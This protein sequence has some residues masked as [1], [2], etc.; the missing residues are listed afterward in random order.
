MKKRLLS[1]LLALSICFGTAVSVSAQDTDDLSCEAAV[2][3][4]NGDVDGDSELTILD[5]V[6]V[7]L[8]INGAQ[9]LSDECEGAADVNGD[10]ITDIV[11]VT[12]MMSHITGVKQIPNTEG[13]V[14]T[15][16][17]DRFYEDYLG[18]SGEDEEEEKP[19]EKV[20][21]KLVVIDAGHQSKANLSPEPIAPGAWQ[22]KAKVTGGTYGRYTGVYEYQLNLIL[23]QKLEKE[24]ESRGYEVIMC[25]TNNDVNISNAERAEIANNA[26]ADAFIR[27]HAN[28]SDY[29]Y[30][31]GAMTICQTKNNPYNAALY[32]KSKSLS[33]YVLD[34]LVASAG[35]KKQYVWETDTMSG[36]NWC[37][38]P[39][40]MVEVGYMTNP[41]EDKLLAT[42][43]YRNKLVKGMAN[44]IDKYFGK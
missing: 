23:A 29:S 21:K 26:H 36:V 35:C 20:E 40:C 18:H 22:T 11:D 15:D 34:E 12:M 13:L 25:R 1:A 39:V 43:D 38:V 16:R 42:D 41:T 32:D 27:I 37:K 24:L 4:G 28:G 19:P 5:V 2:V 9:A 30:V 44:G 6:A 7:V 10:G 14:F 33:T 3:K 31:S 17:A 8:N